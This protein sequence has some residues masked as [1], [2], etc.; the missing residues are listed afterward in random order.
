MKD[1]CEGVLFLKIPRLRTF[2]WQMAACGATPEK[3]VKQQ[4]SHAE[5]T[6]TTTGPDQTDTPTHLLD[7]G[8]KLG[9]LLRLVISLRIKPQLA[10]PPLRRFG[11]RAKSGALV[12]GQIAASHGEFRS[13][14]VSQHNAWRLHHDTQHKG[15]SGSLLVSVCVVTRAGGACVGSSYLHWEMHDHTEGTKC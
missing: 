6:T 12:G 13:G 15:I 11:F 3:C 9:L 1:K 2:S 4:D 5:K 14:L 10:E 8:D 7:P